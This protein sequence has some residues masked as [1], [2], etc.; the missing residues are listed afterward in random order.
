MKLHEVS[1]TSPFGTS[2]PITRG[3]V[4]SFAR[5]PLA[6]M[7]SL[8]AAH[9]EV[10][11]LV[12]DQ[13]RLHFVFGPHYTKQVLAD[14]AR[15]HSHFFALRGGRNS[16]Q[17]RL[18]SGLLSMNGDE[19]RTHRRIVMG[20]FQKRAIANYHDTIVSLTQDMVDSWEFGETINVS[21][22]MIQ[23]MLRLTSSILFGLDEPEFAHHVGQLIERW[24]SLNHEIGPAAFM[25]DSDLVG[26]Y[27]ELLTAANELEAA[28]R[29]LIHR[30]RNSKMGFDVL[31]LL[32]HAHDESGGISDDQLLG[33]LALLF[34]A[35]HLT[36]AHTLT[37]TL[38]LLSQHSEVADALFQE[39]QSTTEGNPP[40]L[41]QLDGLKTLDCVL[42]ESMRILPASSYSQRI[43]ASTVE[44]GPFRLE[45]G[46]VVIFSQF[47]T[48]HLE[49]LYPNPHQFIPERWKTITPSPY[50]YLPF[51]A[52]PRMCIGAA[53]GTMQIKLALATVLGRCKLQAIPWSS[54]GA[55][56]LS[57][58]LFP[59]GSVELQ[60]QPADGHH[61][62]PPVMGNIHTLV[63]LPSAA[64][65]SAT[66]RA[67]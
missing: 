54:V 7:K 56:V 46:A 59:A 25:P 61:V 48:H 63:D 47:I 18:T 3:D 53:L 20:P 29:E 6:C 38:F 64:N 2:L 37:W 23:F 55:R 52:G 17:R 34:G 8:H 40:A 16:A 65:D 60:V 43:A 15:Y 66:R 32:L 39:L 41:D 67:A 35:A 27:D 9:G 10:A 58:M 26:R 22:E 33:H 30:K 28:L 44:L 42:K 24:V 36:S 45:Q 49:S 19:H 50:A 12:D 14:E 4:A 57:T 31:S 1:E 62:A 13:M 11:A 21:H 51:G 5:D